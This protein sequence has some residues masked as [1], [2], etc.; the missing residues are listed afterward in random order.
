MYICWGYVESWVRVIPIYRWTTHHTQPHIHK[1][2]LLGASITMLHLEFVQSF[3][4]IFVHVQFS[5]IEDK[6][7]VCTFSQHLN[8][9]RSQSS[10]LMKIFLW[11]VP[12][13]SLFMLLFLLNTKTTIHC[14]KASTCRV[15]QRKVVL[16]VVTYY[17]TKV[18]YI[19]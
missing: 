12:L 16:H 9:I 11:L 2:W 7:F 13:S 19:S 15:N 6:F 17:S 8:A 18:N 1:Y 10:R 3:P 14:L 5:S 4:Y